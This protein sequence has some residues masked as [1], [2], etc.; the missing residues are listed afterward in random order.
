M[1]DLINLQISHAMENNHGSFEVVDIADDTVSVVISAAGREHQAYV[2]LIKLLNTL[3]IL[4]ERR[5]FCVEDKDN[6]HS[7]VFEILHRSGRGV[8]RDFCEADKEN[9]Q[10][11][12]IDDKLIHKSCSYVTGNTEGGAEFLS[13]VDLTN[14]L[15]EAVAP[16][17][18]KEQFRIAAQI[19]THEAI[20]LNIRASFV[21]TSGIHVQP[22]LVTLHSKG[23]LQ[24]RRVF[25]DYTCGGH[26]DKGEI[27]HNN[28]TFSK[29]NE[30]TGFSVSVKKNTRIQIINSNIAKLSG[31]RRALFKV[32]A[33]NESFIFLHDLFY[34][35]PQPVPRKSVTNDAEWVIG[36]LAKMESLRG[37]R[38][39]Y[40]D[41][42][43]K[44]DEMVHAGEKFMYFYAGK[45]P[46]IDILAKLPSDYP[47]TTPGRR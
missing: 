44:I 1:Y 41:T 38:V 18:S 34:V 16:F 5:V 12:D 20:F 2:K 32:I 11:N 42:I 22:I 33:M 13:S 39:F 14:A 29:Y 7:T 19:V 23:A 21:G 26:N 47:D 24:G 35:T 43:Y 4:G 17:A 31:E 37:R 30:I 3:N 8:R 10:D 27:L 15:K 36:T 25:Y 46:L 28:D 9:I 40:K 6:I 45:G